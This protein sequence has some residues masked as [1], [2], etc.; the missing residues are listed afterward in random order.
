MISA[1]TAKPATVTASQLSKVDPGKRDRRSA[2]P[3]EE[4]ALIRATLCGSE[5]AQALG[6]TVCSH[7]PVP[8][9]CRR[10]LSSGHDPD[11]PLHA[12]RGETLCLRVRSI[13]EGARLAV[14]TVGNGRPMFAL[15]GCAGGA[16]ASLVR[17]NKQAL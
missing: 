11:R 7:A 1:K 8:E 15:D 6:L 16:A 13:G 14:K 3:S 12:Y 2:A 4:R 17:K 9:L 10:L 5:E